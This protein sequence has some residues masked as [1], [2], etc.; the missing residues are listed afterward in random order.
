MSYTTVA[1]EP[2]IKSPPPTTPGEP[3]KL[4][5]TCSE[6][7]KKVQIYC[8]I[9]FWE[10]ALH[11]YRGSTKYH[12]EKYR[13]VPMVEEEYI[14]FG[15]N[16]QGLFRFV[17]GAEQNDLKSLIDE[18]INYIQWYIWDETTR[19]PAIYFLEN[20]LIPG[21]TSL[22]GT[23]KTKNLSSAI[24]IWLLIIGIALQKPNDVVKEPYTREG[25]LANF[26]SSCKL[27]E[28]DE[29]YKTVTGILNSEIS[30]FAVSAKELVGADKLQ[31]INKIFQNVRGTREV[32]SSQ[33]DIFTT[34]QTLINKITDE[35]DKLQ[36]S[37]IDLCKSATLYI[38]QSKNANVGPVKK[39]P[40]VNIE[41]QST[42]S[43][44]S[45]TPN[46]VTGTH[47]TPVDVQIHQD[48]VQI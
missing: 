5:E 30:P 48:N 16:W 34:N 23:Y 11:P 14:K 29:N 28:T 10:I 20:L 32:A 6:T 8:V 40:A 33:K 1:V 35:I 25:F 9:A 24:T 18:L 26:K 31:E 36:K 15:I 45:K 21:L 4:L 3:F 44:A 17:K 19:E 37:Y 22:Q 46:S 13:L 43:T 2:T 27:P 41:Q 38:K 42:E 12:V 39:S 7:M 47:A